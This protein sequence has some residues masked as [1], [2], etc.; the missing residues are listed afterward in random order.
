MKDYNKLLIDFYK[1]YNPEKV[2]EVSD[3]LKKYEGQEEELLSKLY[4]KYNVNQN[5]F[6]N[7]RTS[8]PSSP[9]DINEAVYNENV[10]PSKKNARI[11]TIVG[12]IVLLITGAILIFNFYTPK[13]QKAAED[14][15]NCLSSVLDKQ[16]ITEKDVKNVYDSCRSFLNVKYAKKMNDPKWMA[17]LNSPEN[18]QR[19]K[20]IMDRIEEK[21]KSQTFNVDLYDFIVKYQEYK[22]GNDK[23]NFKIKIS[24]LLLIEG[25]NNNGDYIVQLIAE[26]DKN[27][28][29]FIMYDDDGEEAKEENY[30]ISF[31]GDFFGDILDAGF[32]TTWQESIDSKNEGNDKLFASC[33]Y[34]GQFVKPVNSS[35]TGILGK[36]ICKFQ[37]KPEVQLIPINSSPDVVKTFTSNSGYIAKNY[38]YYNYSFK[39]IVELKGVLKSIEDTK[40]GTILMLDE[41]ELIETKKYPQDSPGNGYTSLESSNSV[42]NQ[43]DK[44]TFKSEDCEEFLKGYEKFMEDY[45]VI[46]KKYKANPSDMSIL[47]EYTKMV[48]KSNE[49]ADKTA[50]CA[51]DPKF[52]SKFVAIQT[53][54]LNA[55]SD[56]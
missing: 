20:A 23:L 30:Y 7:V 22:E 41:C 40:R 13:P 25:V 3:L 50:D 52:T 47:T 55:S 26:K 8:M 27:G 17:E 46:V 56:L 16:M 32:N 36:A 6:E 10:K 18:E 15:C 33:E 19:M 53:K 39:Q 28:K 9:K 49:W 43:E 2:S 42:E 37:N 31:V 51:S 5:D 14:A 38:K 44:A 12:L 4:E 54:I 21:Y 11:Y 35:T 34:R 29:K 1:K 24:G 48:S 45:L